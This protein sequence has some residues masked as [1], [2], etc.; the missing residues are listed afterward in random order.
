MYITVGREAK[1]FVEQ[2]IKQFVFEKFNMYF[3]STY[4]QSLENNIPR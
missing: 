2:Y 4:I 1:R 3:E